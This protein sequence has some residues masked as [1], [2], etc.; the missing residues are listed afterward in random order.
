MAEAAIEDVAHDA[1][2]GAGPGAVRPQRDALGAQ[3]LGE[4]ALGHA[5]LDDGI[6][7]GGVDLADAVHPAEVEDDVARRHRAGI[8]V[9]PALA[10]ADRI[11]RSEERRVGNECVSTG[12]S[13]W[14]PARENKTTTQH[15]K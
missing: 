1:G 7:K 13:R 14:E 4:L 2:V 9:A 3:M 8:A 11:A 12:R 10:P 5:R 15:I 6:G